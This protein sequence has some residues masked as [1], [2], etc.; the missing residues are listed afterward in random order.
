MNRTLVRISGG[1]IIVF[2]ETWWIRPSRA[3]QV[4]ERCPMPQAFVTVPWAL[5]KVA[6]G[7]LAAETYLIL[8]PSSLD[9]SNSTFTN[10]SVV[11]VWFHD[12]NSISAL[13]NIPKAL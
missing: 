7:G 9:F 5:N 6:S 12:L 11:I 3:L 8:F 4:L 1:K 2:R 10:L 13:P